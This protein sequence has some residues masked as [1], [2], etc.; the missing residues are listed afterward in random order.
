MIFLGSWLAIEIFA[1]ICIGL[2][3]TCVVGLA[4]ICIER[5]PK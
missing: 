1:A 5:K 3:A 4:A 2:I